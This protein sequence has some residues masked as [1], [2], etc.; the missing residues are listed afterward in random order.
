MRNQINYLKFT[1][2]CWDDGL[3]ADDR[4]ANA[5][6]L[7]VGPPLPELLGAPYKRTMM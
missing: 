1:S 7:W 3:N 4:A 5:D 2:F 6:A